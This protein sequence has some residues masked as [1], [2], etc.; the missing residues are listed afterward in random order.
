MAKYYNADLLV[1]HAIPDP[2]LTRTGPLNAEAQDLHE[3]LLEHNRRVALSYLNAIRS[4]FEHQVVSL[5]LRLLEGGE[6]RTQLVDVIRKESVDLVVICSH[7][8]TGYSDMPTGSVARFVLEHVSTPVL[9]IGRE[10][11]PNEAGRFSAKEA[12]DSR[13]PALSV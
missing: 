9:M 10:K 11:E 7:G 13:P 2:G 8:T 3:R 4:R 12:F 6:V 1:V 5:S